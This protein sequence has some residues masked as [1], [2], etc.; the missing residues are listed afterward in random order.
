MD[1]KEL[2]SRFAEMFRKAREDASMSQEEIAMKIG[3]SRKTVEN[4]ETGTSIPSLVRSLQWFEALNAQPLPYFLDA[5]YPG[6]F[7]ENQSKDVDRALISI[8][9]A[10]PTDLKRKLL[11]ILAG[12]HGSSTV[13]VLE[14][15]TAHL[16]VPLEYRINIAQDVETNYELAQWKGMLCCQ[17]DI[18]PD[19]ATLSRSISLGKKAVFE[20][21]N[22]YTKGLLK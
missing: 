16:H 14:L 7:N 18:R 15:A 10:L 4:W 9:S 3:I 2:T 13:G 5:L 17:D 20:G 21:K 19:L 6:K 11:F 12:N 8:V 1:E 22:S